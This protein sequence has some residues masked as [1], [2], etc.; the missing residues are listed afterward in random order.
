MGPWVNE[1]I[2]D[3]MVVVMTADKNA[4]VGE[5]KKPRKKES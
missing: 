5:D 3:Q 1:V 4:E 2:G